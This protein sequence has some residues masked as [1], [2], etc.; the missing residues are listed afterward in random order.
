MLMGGIEGEGIPPTARLNQ[1]VNRVPTSD[2]GF[3]IASKLAREIPG[4]GGV[5]RKIDLIKSI[6]D[7]IQGPTPVPAPKPMGE[8]PPEAPEIVRQAWAMQRGGQ[9][10][11]PAQ[12]GEA[13]GKLNVPRGTS[14]VNTQPES[15]QAVPLKVPAP[16]A[17][18]DP[19]AGAR[20][21]VM[22]PSQSTTIA[23]HGY[24]P[25]SQT[26]V[27]QF[28]NGNV[29]EYRG[30]PQEVWDAYKNSESQ[31]SFFANNI[32][33]RYTTNL[34]GSVGKTAGQKV[35]EALGRKPSNP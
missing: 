4:I 12:T 28:K 26:M 15:Y 9:P 8:L 35:R 17:P 2:P 30:V 6:N 25:E 1:A 24:V 20:T 33:G 13:L 34:R 19:Y 23:H 31:G 10:P 32:K 16:K 29:Y 7:R 3:G 21:P 27:L 11:N 18:V 22:E 14:S 5:L